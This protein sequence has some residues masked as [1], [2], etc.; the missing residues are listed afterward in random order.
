MSFL[1]ALEP[2]DSRWKLTIRL[3][4]PMIQG[5]IADVHP[6]DTS[7]SLWL[8]GFGHVVFT[9]EQVTFVPLGGFRAYII[10]AVSRYEV[11]SLR[12]S[13]LSTLSEFIALGRSSPSCVS[14][15]L[16]TVPLNSEYNFETYCHT[17][18]YY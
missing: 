15:L 2:Q 4:L 8:L 18:L 3:S 13:S 6:N 5:N 14:R 1:V 11:Y 7:F 10:F 16:S 9:N 17:S 12:L